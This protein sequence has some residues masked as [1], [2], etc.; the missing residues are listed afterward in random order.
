MWRKLRITIL[1]LILLFVALRTYFDRVHT[2]DWDAPLQVAVFPINADGSPTAEGYIREL[3]TDA[4]QPI[5]AFLEREAEH[6]ELQ[7]DRPA[8]FHLQHPI[9][10][11][12]PMPDASAGL[13]SS[14]WWSL[15][16]RYW[17]WKVADA[18]ELEPDIQLFVLFHDPERTRAVPHSIGLQKGLFAIVNVFAAE[19]MRGSNHVVIAHELLHI[20]GASD[21]YDLQTAQ[22][23]HPHGY[24]EPMNTPLHPQS[25]AEIMGGRIP[26]SEDEA[27]VPES[28][29]QVVIGAVTAHEI[30]WTE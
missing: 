20:L 27:Q 17:A 3:P 16:T 13:L 22:P 9:R 11:L 15:K 21:K 7:L 25:F 23:L 1:L 28:L 26:L 5:E 14:M 18:G 6:F 10:D 8:R 12:P 29:D 24:A 2:T 4:F 30:G 19:H